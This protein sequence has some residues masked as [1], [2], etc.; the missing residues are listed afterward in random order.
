MRS[1]Q[2]LN[3][4][5]EIASKQREINFDFEKLENNPVEKIFAN[6]LSVIVV[7]SCHSANA[8]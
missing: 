6:I 2:Q 8:L 7:V 5:L 4:E 1:A 3:A